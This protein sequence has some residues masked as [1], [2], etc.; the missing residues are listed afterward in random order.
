M[1]DTELKSLNR[2]M[3]VSNLQQ[4]FQTG[5]GHETQPSQM[6]LARQFGDQSK[7]QLGKISK[8]KQKLDSNRL[9]R[10]SLVK[11]FSESSAERHTHH[12]KHYQGS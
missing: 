5:G 3:K 4:Q 11:E 7:K 9:M 10:G 12:E 8:N 2:T 6:E 1:A